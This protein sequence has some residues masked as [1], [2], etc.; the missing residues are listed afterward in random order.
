MNFL[1]RLG[2][3]QKV[4]L[5]FVLLVIAIGAFVV[6]RTATSSDTPDILEEDQQFVAV[7]RGD[8]VSEISVS[9]S[10][11]FP[12][13]Q[14]LTFGSQGVVA[15]VLVKEGQRV[16]AGDVIARLDAETIARLEREVTEA[17]VGLREAQDELNDLMTPPDLSVAEARQSVAMAQEAL[18]DANETLS[19]ILAPS[20]VQ[21]T[22]MAGRVAA[23]A[24]E[25][26]DSEDALGDL[27]TP[28]D[29]V[30]A[31]AAR[32]VVEAEIALAALEDSPT[33]LEVA[34]AA[35]RVSRAAV[36]LQD[37]KEAL[38]SYEAGVNDE[39]V[40]RDLENARRD[41]DAARTNL[42]NAMTDLEVAQR[43]GEVYIDNALAAQDEA[44]QAYADTYTKWLG[45]VTPYGSIDP[46]YEAALRSYGV[47][48]SSLFAAPNRGTGLAFGQLIPADD[49]DTAWS[50]SRVHVWLHFSRQAFEATCDRNDLP[51]FGTVC[52]EEEFR[53]TGKAYQD[54]I[55]GRAKAEAD[56]HNSLAAVQERID[57]SQEAIE[58]VEDRIEELTEPVDPVVL[59]QMQSSVEVAEEDFNDASQKL[60]DLTDP[61]DALKSA[62]DLRDLEV[63]QATLA[64]A[65]ERL[66]ELTGSANTAA[67]ADLTAKVEVARAN[68]DDLKDQQTELLSGQDRTDY[69]AA[70]HAVEVAQLKLDQRQEELDELLGDPDPIDLDLLTAKVEAAKTLLRESHERLSDASGL[71]AP[72]DGF[73][74][75]VNVEEGEDIEPSDVVAVLVDTGVVEIDGSVDE[76]D[77]LSIELGV[78]A[79]VKMD[80]LPDES[81]GGVVSFV[82]AEPL[83]NQGGVVSYPIRVEIEL[84]EEMKAPEGLSAVASIVLS[85]EID[86]LLI[87]VNAIQG[88]FDH[89]IVHLIVDEETVET[90]VALGSSDDFWTVVTEGLSEGD[91]VVAVAPEGQDVQFFN[92]DGE[93]DNGGPR[94]REQ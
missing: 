53:S 40:A 61:S 68:L 58:T 86:V 38:E 17:N 57:S 77:V 7:R 16:S 64:D 21:T 32:S 35:D 10:V 3:W 65:R 92:G 94:P 81:L 46:D 74:S 28:S 15:E 51:P 69:A 13:R 71:P 91:V 4:A 88:S 89:P 75:R 43:D 50:E 39:D 41:L 1:S 11:S 5:V 80:A 56:A 90:P 37:A 45:I 9:G 2:R 29:L 59:A 31:D 49:P 42:A 48:L 79:E 14:N 73:I 76:I 36:A 84:P 44:G 27:V 12:E 30:V 87:P 82:G 8:L 70:F 60:S 52:I 25:L 93:E 55:D 85:R 23:A 6:Y 20:D 83:E 24:R 34:Q 54:A 66:S 63:A 33:A 19:E 62:S 47:D 78:E 22:E 26:E 67:I 72:S 18:D